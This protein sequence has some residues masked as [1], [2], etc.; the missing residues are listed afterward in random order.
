FR[1]ETFEHLGGKVVGELNWN[2]GTSDYSPQ[3]TEIAA[4]NPRPDMIFS[5][6]VMP[7]GGTFLRQAK[8]AGL[9][10][11]VFGTDTFDD[12]AML[13][14]AGPGGDLMNL[15]SHGVASE[16]SA[17]RAVYEDCTARGEKIGVVFI[18]PGGEAVERVRHAIET[19][20]TVVPAAINEAIS[21][22]ETLK[23][24][25]ADSITFKGR[26]GVP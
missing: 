11:P 19:A 20:G 10:I 14:A 17:L 15:G 2:L 12:P 21:N 8:A 7:D 5:A 18:G 24:I 13:A 9:D 6:F 4:M 23:G 16:G 1:S 25:T 26:G 22:I 3:I